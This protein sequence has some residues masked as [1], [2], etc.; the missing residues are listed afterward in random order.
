[1]TSARKLADEVRMFLIRF[2]VGVPVDDIKSIFDPD[3]GEQLLRKL[4]AI[5][6][7]A[8]RERIQRSVTSSS[9]SKKPR[10][11]TAEDAKVPKRSMK[12]LYESLQRINLEFR[13]ETYWPQNPNFEQRLTR[14]KGETRR[15][16]AR[17]FMRR[18]GTVSSALF[19]EAIDDELRLVRSLIDPTLMGGEFLP[20]RRGR[21]TEIARIGYKT[22]FSNQVSIRASRDPS[23]T[24]KYR[25]VDEFGEKYRITRSKSERP[26][27]LGQ[28]I[29]MIDT[30]RHNDEIGFVKSAWS[31]NL[32]I[33]VD[34][35]T[36][37]TIAEVSS[38]FYADLGNAYLLEAIHF[39]AEHENTHVRKR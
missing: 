17:E 29:D 5:R 12:S 13:P 30:V 9:V 24:I 38:A 4:I 27:T 32:E 33:G 15:N 11:R 8:S 21:E 22:M 37:V 31:Q 28:L 34:L 1:V 10:P 19:R 3:Y 6:E 7:P 14:V 25:I 35:I 39:I 2:G 23:G 26:L 16:E 20:N 18:S 36:A